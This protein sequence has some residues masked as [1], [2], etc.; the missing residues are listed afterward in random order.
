[1]EEDKKIEG[2]TRKQKNMSIYNGDTEARWGSRCR[3]KENL[4]NVVGGVF[5]E[6][7]SEGRERQG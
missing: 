3:G 6:G 2:K 1:M 4:I 7:E 5:G